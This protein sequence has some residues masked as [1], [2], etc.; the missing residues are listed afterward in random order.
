MASKVGQY[1]TRKGLISEEYL[2]VRGRQPED[3]H[4]LRGNQAFPSEILAL[5]WPLSL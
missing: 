4:R 5:C 1:F 3:S 2:T